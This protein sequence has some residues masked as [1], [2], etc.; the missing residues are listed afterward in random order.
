[1][2]FG[3][4]PL[5]YLIEAF[6]QRRKEER[7]WFSQSLWRRVYLT[8]TGRAPKWEYGATILF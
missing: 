8:V 7:A 4:S 3:I 5:Q 1:M 2:A 6:E